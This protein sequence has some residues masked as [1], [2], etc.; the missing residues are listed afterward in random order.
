MLGEYSWT[1]NIILVVLIIIFL[2]IAVCTPQTHTGR[3]AQS[4]VLFIV[5]IFFIIIALYLVCA[6]AEVAAIY[7]HRMSKDWSNC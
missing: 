3:F 6:S 7:W 4:F 1:V 5:V 2:V